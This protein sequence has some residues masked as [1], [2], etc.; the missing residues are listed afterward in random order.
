MTK[1]IS[2][3]AYLFFFSFHLIAQSGLDSLAIKGCLVADSSYEG[4]INTYIKI[5]SKQRPYILSYFNTGKENCFVVKIPF[6]GP[7]TFFITASHITYQATTVSHYISDASKSLTIEIVMPLQKNILGEVVVK[8]PPIWVRGDT[9]FFK[10]DFFKEGE[11]QKLKDLIVKMPGFE[12]DKDGNL[13]YKK[14]RIEKIMIE[15]EEIFADKIKLLLNSVPVHV[16][17]TVQAVENQTDNKLLKGLTADNKVFLNLGIKKEKIKAAFGDGEAGMGTEGRYLFAPTIF[18]L[19]GKTKIGFIGNE[20]STG[21]GFDWGED[22]E[23]KNEAG[24]EVEQ[25]MMNSQYLQTINNFSSKRYIKNQKWDNRMQV[26]KPIGKKLKNKTELGFVMDKQTQNT[27]YNSTLYND[28][29]YFK[30]LDTNAIRHKPM[31]FS[32]SEELRWNIDSSK[33]LITSVQFYYN[34]T[35]SRHVGLYKEE[36]DSY[37]VQNKIGNNWKNIALNTEL[38]NRK[39]ASLAT[40]LFLSVSS[41]DFRQKARGISQDWPDIFQLPG[42]YKILDQTLQNKTTSIKAE[43]EI[44]KKTKKALYITNIS[45]NWRKFN[46]NNEMIFSDSAKINPEVKSDYFSNKGKYELIDLTASSQRSFRVFQQPLL[47][48]VGYGIAHATLFEMYNKKSFTTPL[49]SFEISQQTKISRP[50]VF[51][52]SVK[53]FQRQ[54]EPWNLHRI[55]LPKTVASFQRNAN[56]SQPI[57]TLSGNLSMGINWGNFISSYT[58]IFYQK[59]FSGFIG[60]STFNQLLQTALDTLIQKPINSFNI[61]NNITFPSLWLKT[62]FELGGVYSI[63]QGYIIY[64]GKLLPVKYNWYNAMAIIKKNWNKK[65]YVTL[66]THYINRQNN[67]PGNVSRNIEKRISDIRAVLRQRAIIKKNITLTG[68]LEWYR[69]NMFTNNKNSILFADIE[70]TYKIPKKPW[71]LNLVFSNITNERFFYSQNNSLLVQSFYSFSL[72]KRNIF[73][74][75]R[76]EL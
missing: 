58:G 15:G 62:K 38:T 76:Y 68:S 71:S 64:Q 12:I 3:L 6:T 41:S 46:I 75:V 54:A 33:E 66:E 74:S 65:Y 36:F 39:S 28:T 20:N 55:N 60:T 69:Y 43:A 73:F 45:A 40:R 52:Y 35:T 21:S 50:F 27:Y 34:A 1:L 53:Y 70:C 23:L 29:S 26:N 4:I 32:L 9:T 11:E 25:W 5:T 10:A 48:K 8:S 31:I 13:M 72:I 57:K 18:A 47:L 24:K 61:S 19:Y 7:D 17:N 67:L 16:L 44:L 63:N 49:Y 22:N 59:N 56:I 51:N 42:A 30:R 37:S 2:I 14:R